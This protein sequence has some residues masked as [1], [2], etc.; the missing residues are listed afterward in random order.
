PAARDRRTGARLSQDSRAGAGAHPDAR[1]RGS[2]SG[3]SV[4]ESPASDPAHPLERVAPPPDP[5]SRPAHADEPDRRRDVPRSVW[6]E[7]RGDG[8]DAGGDA[9][10]L[11]APRGS[12]HG[13]RA[14]RSRAVPA[15][16]A[17]RSPWKSSTP[18]S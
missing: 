5:S 18:I 17:R 9:G 10:A 11:V 8:G 16:P 12:G 7:P 15:I 6:T 4:R 1:A 13:A 3:D 14:T 2:R